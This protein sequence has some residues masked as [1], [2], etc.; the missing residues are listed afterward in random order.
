MFKGGLAGHSEVETKYHT[1]THLMHQALRDVLGPEVFQKGSNINTERL[2][3][4][5]SFDRK[6]TEDEIK[7]VEEIINGKIKEDLVVDHLFMNLPEAKKMNAIGLFNEKYA[8]TVSI[9]AIGPNY[10]LDSSAKDLRDRGGYYSAEFC[11]GPHVEHIGIISGIKILKEE[12]V[13]QGVR[14]IYAELAA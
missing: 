11:G 12:S 6:L 1:A 4:D 9:Y 10:N 13:S 5:F 3:F 2:R 7:R 8:E 14:R